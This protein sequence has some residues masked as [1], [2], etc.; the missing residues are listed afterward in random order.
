MII[1]SIQAK[2]GRYATGVNVLVE[3]KQAGASDKVISALAEWWYLNEYDV[4]SIEMSL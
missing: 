4:Q 1:S 3:L 2:T